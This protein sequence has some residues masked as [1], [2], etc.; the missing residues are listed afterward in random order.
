[1]IFREPI[2]PKAFC[3]KDKKALIQAKKFEK[4]SG[5]YMDIGTCKLKRVNIIFK[6]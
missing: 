3:E 2:R 4:D 6:P 1:M 5:K